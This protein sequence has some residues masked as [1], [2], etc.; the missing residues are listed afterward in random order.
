MKRL[1]RY[2]S[3][4]LHYLVPLPILL[5]AL[6]AWNYEPAAL[7][8][9][10]LHVFDEFLRLKPRVY[11]PSPVR[12]VDIDDDSLEQFGQW[13]W[14][15]T[16]LAKLVTQLDKQGAAAIAFDILFLEPDR[17]TPSRIVTEMSEIAADDP[18]VARFK[19][20]PDHDQA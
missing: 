16:L 1:R 18:V 5:A 14:P 20:F 19:E 17:T 10:R 13:P 3:R 11:E 7:V 9:F 2:V 12:V 15:R 4:N 6:L 8:E